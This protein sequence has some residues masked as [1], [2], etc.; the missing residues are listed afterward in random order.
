MWYDLSKNAHTSSGKHEA[1]VMIE[2][3]K[4]EFDRLRE[5]YQKECGL[6]VN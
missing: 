1:K 4:K 6:N 3:L 2:A 5:K